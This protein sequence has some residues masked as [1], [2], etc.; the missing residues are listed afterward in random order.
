MPKRW[1]I[2]GLAALLL[3]TGVVYAPGLHGEFQFDD[4]RTVQFNQGIRRLDNFSLA[5]ALAEMVRGKRILTN[6]SFAIDYRIAGN[7]PF[8]FHATNLGIHLAAILLVFF[9]T[10]KVLALSGTMDRDLLA[11]AVGAVFALHPLQTQAVAYISQRAESLASGFYLA[12]LLL[13]LAAERRGRC[14]VGAGIYAA[15]FVLFALG[16]SAKVIVVTLPVAYLLMGLLPGPHGLLVR[17]LKRLALATPF[18]AYAL[19]TTVLAVADLKG[20]DAGFFIPFLPPGRYF[21][22]QWHVLLTY[23]RLL[24]WPAGQNVDWDFSLARGFADPAVIGSG[25]LLAGLL[26][27]A[28][29]LLFRCRSRADRAGVA[30]RAAAFGVVWFFLLLAPTSSVVPLAD[31]LMEHR[32][33]LASWGVFFAIAILADSLLGR[34]HA[35]GLSRFGPIALLGLCA[36]LAACTYL[37]VGLWKSKLLLWS[38][39]VVK[40]PHKA[41]THLGLGN[42]YHLAGQIQPAID[43]YRNALNLAASDP[44]WIR[45]RIHEKL[46]LALLAQERAE[47]AIAAAQAGLVED[48]NHTALLE[49]LAMAHLQ[50]HDLPEAAAAA[51]QSVR[52][53]SQPASSLVVLGAVRLQMGDQS[54]AIE[55]FE[56]A[57]KL[58]PEELQGHLWLARAYRA[59]G[60]EQ[61]ACDVLRA[62]RASD[63][64]QHEELKQALAGCPPR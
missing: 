32:L 13:L 6:L 28:G 35:R 48:P 21:L 2:A 55:A 22:T 26:V 30:A 8:V 49:T 62:F 42:A 7:D 59:Q 19:L 58:E 53:A 61:Q 18:L 45:T 20:E 50:R 36:A 63:L 46:A 43:E 33:Y 41:R 1:L 27:A 64:Q 3:L 52:T 39:A 60:R 5:Q 29:I 56:R 38:D 57:V 51:E 12:S 11:L 15:S 37:R 17:P 14:A 44:T 54:R 34:L 24:F 25:L 16:L 47:D 4:L 10:H 23:L 40:S 9:F 31:V